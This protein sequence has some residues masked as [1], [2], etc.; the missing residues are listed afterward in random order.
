MDSNTIQK[1]DEFAS[2]R[3]A[4]LS[5]S[6]LALKD[7]GQAM[8]L[9][10]V[11]AKSGLI[12]GPLR[13]KPADVLTVLLKG[14]ELGLRPMQALSE[15]HVIDGK[16]GASA[17]LKVALCLQRADVCL[18]FRLV[19]STPAKAVFETQRKGSPQP[20]RMEYTIEQASVAGL[21]GKQ[22]WKSHPAAML[23]ARASGALADAVYADIV[24]GLLLIDELDEMRERV[25]GSGTT[26]PLTVAP[27][28]PEPE[29]FD[30]S[31]TAPAASPPS[32]AQVVS[33][34]N[35]V[36]A[37]AAKAKVLEG[38]AAAQGGKDLE[39]LVPSIRALPKS[40]QEEV[41]KVYSARRAELGR[42]AA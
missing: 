9:A 23:R 19:E 39:A 22:N 13:E 25:V 5:P 18:Y 7:I 33:A 29:E 41:R 3:G 40:E 28:P 38:I 36:D 37:A 10:K 27:P 35:P 34:P 12:P 24:Q 21:L 11:L 20:T 2:L 1:A 30:W 4:E 15:M 14:H 17:K 16:A 26:A 32:P 31:A 42:V 8:D 6:G